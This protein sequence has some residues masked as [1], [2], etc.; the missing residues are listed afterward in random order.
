MAEKSKHP[1]RKK[2]GGF[3]KFRKVEAVEDKDDLRDAKRRPR[4]DK[5]E[6]RPN[7]VDEQNTTPRLNKYV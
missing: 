7:P 1:V 3:D 6:K 2:P 5:A 4:K